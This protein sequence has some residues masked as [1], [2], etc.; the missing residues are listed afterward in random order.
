MKPPDNF[1]DEEQVLRGLE[2]ALREFQEKGVSG[3]VTLL[4]C[5]GRGVRVEKVVELEKVRVG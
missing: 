3:A 5:E 2:E 1:P 4:V